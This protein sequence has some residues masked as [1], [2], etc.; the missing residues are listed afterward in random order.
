MGAVNLLVKKPIAIIV[1]VQGALKLLEI[2][3]K[4]KAGGTVSE[5][6]EKLKTVYLKGWSQEIFSRPGNDF[7]GYRL[8]M[9]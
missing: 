5:K 7:K 1:K 4:L 3:K 9:A 2:K 6:E 8:I